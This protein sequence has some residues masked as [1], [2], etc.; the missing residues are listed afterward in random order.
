MPAFFINLAIYL[1]FLA[2]LTAF[3]IVL[4][5]PSEDTCD[6]E[7]GPQCDEG[8]QVYIYIFTKQLRQERFTH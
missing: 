8:K 3:V 7:Q 4:P 1:V 5:L 2:F 6:G